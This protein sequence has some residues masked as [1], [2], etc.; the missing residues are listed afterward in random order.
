MSNIKILLV[1][2][3]RKTEQSSDEL[4]GI[5]CGNLLPPHPL[6]VRAPFLYDLVFMLPPLLMLLHQK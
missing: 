3:P 6:L 1:K 2:P 4:L 5:Y